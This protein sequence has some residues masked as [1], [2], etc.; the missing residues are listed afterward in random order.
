VDTVSGTIFA[1]PRKLL[2]DMGNPIVNGLLELGLL[3]KPSWNEYWLTEE[4]SRLADILIE[5]GN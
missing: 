1:P 4:G 3:S 2:A 5:Q